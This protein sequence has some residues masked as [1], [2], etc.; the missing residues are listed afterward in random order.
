MRVD[1]HQ[2]LVPVIRY[3]EQHFNEPLNLPEVA[4]LANLS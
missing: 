2:R 1:Y 3:L 4:A